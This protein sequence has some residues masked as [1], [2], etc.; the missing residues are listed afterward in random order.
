MKLKMPE[1]LKIVLFTVALAILFIAGRGLCEEQNQPF[2]SY[3]SGTVEVRLYTDYF[4]PPCRAMEPD[5][6]PLLVNLL[7]K[8]A[9]HLTLVDV[10]FNRLTPLYARYLLYALKA[11]NHPEY[12]FRV[13]KT[14]QDAAGKE[15]GTQE[16]IERLFKEKVIAYA[17]WDPKPVFDR[18][19]ALLK[20]DKVTATPTCVIIENS[21]KRVFVGGANIIRALKALSEPATDGAIPSGGERRP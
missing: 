2:P 19:N 11:N 17:A 14:L 15:V 21:R 10:P 1:Q 20:E 6:E 5:I 13:R 3:G 18:Y 9:I 12:A 8:N 16:Q 4:C 7:K